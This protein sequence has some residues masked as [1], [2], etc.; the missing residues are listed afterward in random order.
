MI[1]PVIF[2]FANKTLGKTGD[3]AMRAMTLYA[4]NSMSSVLFA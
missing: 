2:T 1:Q 3:D 4:M